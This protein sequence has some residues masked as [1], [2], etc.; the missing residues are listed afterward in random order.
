VPAD[1]IRA[2]IVEEALRDTAL[3]RQFNCVVPINYPL[4]LVDSPMPASSGSGRS[5]ASFARWAL[6]VTAPT[7]SMMESF[8]SRMQ[9][10]LATAMFD[11]IEV[12][13]NRQRHHSALGK[14]S[15]IEFEARRRPTTAPRAQSFN[16]TTLG[17]GQSLHQAQCDSERFADAPFTRSVKSAHVFYISVC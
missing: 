9:V 13:H 6:L 11:S 7:V 5:C 17:A 8:W 12:F 15:P 16:S 2:E 4:N 10:E 14:M 1:H 3:S